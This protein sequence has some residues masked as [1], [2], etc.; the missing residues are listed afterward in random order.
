MEPLYSM[1]YRNR[2]HFVGNFKAPMSCKYQES[3]YLSY[4]LAHNT[5]CIAT[6]CKT[7]M[8][9]YSRDFSKFLAMLQAA[10]TCKSSPWFHLL[11]ISTAL[12]QLPL[13]QDQ[14]RLH[15]SNVW[16][17]ATN[18]RPSV[19]D[20]CPQISKFTL[21]PY[22]VQKSHVQGKICSSVGDMVEQARW[23]SL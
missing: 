4:T 21:S 18:Y 8:G 3:V 22:L 23:Q 20:H 12:V 13:S 16:V 9:L 6:A 17:P 7:W 15:S 14:L 11:E 19:P 5:F 2:A 10:E 1:P